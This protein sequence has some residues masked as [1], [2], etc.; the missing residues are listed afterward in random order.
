MRRRPDIFGPVVIRRNADETTF[1]GRHGLMFCRNFWGPGNQGDHIDLWNRDHLKSGDSSYIIRSEE[2]WFWEIA[3]APN[4]L[5]DM[6]PSSARTRPIKFRSASSATDKEKEI[7]EW[8]LEN[9]SDRYDMS[10]L[11]RLRYSRQP[12][13]DNWPL[14][15]IVSIPNDNESWDELAIL[16]NENE[17]ISENGILSYFG[18]TLTLHLDEKFEGGKLMSSLYRLS[19]LDEWQWVAYVFDGQSYYESIPS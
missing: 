19:P 6:L 9:H 1:L 17:Q 2:V 7:G 13:V 5:T 4:A 11:P 16:G 10:L 18:G 3:G 8:F 12:L 14:M 15:L